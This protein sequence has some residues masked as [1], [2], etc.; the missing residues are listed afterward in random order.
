[1]NAA[2]ERERAKR[3][4]AIETRS[5]DIEK[6]MGL[7]MQQLI[8]PG[9]GGTAKA[10]YIESTAPLER[11]V[12]KNR[13]EFEVSAAELRR[14]VGVSVW[15]YVSA[16]AISEATNGLVGSLQMAYGPGSMGAR[17]EAGYDDKSV[18]AHTAIVMACQVDLRKKLDRWRSVM[19]VKDVEFSYSFFNGLGRQAIVS[20]STFGL[21][22]RAKMEFIRG[23]FRLAYAETMLCLSRHRLVRVMLAGPFA[24]SMLKSDDDFE[25]ELSAISMTYGGKTLSDKAEALKFAIGAVYFWMNLSGQVVKEGLE[26]IWAA[27]DSVLETR[28]DA[29]LDGI[30]QLQVSF[31]T[32][33]DHSTNAAERSSPGVE[34]AKAAGERAVPVPMFAEVGL[35]LLRTLVEHGGD[36]LACLGPFVALT[37]QAIRLAS[38]HSDLW[39]KRSGLV[40]DSRNE[41]CLAS[42]G[43]VAAACEIFRGCADSGSPYESRVQLLEVNDEDLEAYERSGSGWMVGPTTLNR[44]TRIRGGVVNQVDARTDVYVP[45]DDD[46]PSP[47]GFPD[48]VKMA[49][50]H[51]VSERGIRAK[52]VLRR[53]GLESSEGGEMDQHAERIE[54]CCAVLGNVIDSVTMRKGGDVGRAV[55]R[56]DEAI[57]ERVG[58][59]RG[60]LYGRGFTCFMA[61]MRALV[62]TSLTGIGHQVTGR[63]RVLIPGYSVSS[64]D[65]GDL[66]SRDECLPSWSCFGDHR[67]FG[68]E[69]EGWM[70]TVL[71]RSAT[72]VLMST[73]RAAAHISRL[74]AP[75]RPGAVREGGIDPDEILFVRAWV[76]LVWRVLGPSIVEEV[77]EELVVTKCPEEAAAV[78]A[79]AAYNLRKE[80]DRSKLVR[81]VKATAE[82]VEHAVEEM[83]EE[84]EEED[85]EDDDASVI[86]G[87][88]M[89]SSV[90]NGGAVGKIVP[91]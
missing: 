64:R 12:G 10:R 38:F 16:R 54:F 47:A 42:M 39:K 25:A 49:M 89:A 41:V 11:A 32:A 59:I 88:T 83:A 13:A 80:G 4:K 35:F 48:S 52:Q 65:M 24:G 21:E 8:A 1:M 66:A 31:K 14:C 78:F 87:F 60:L 91:Q 27:I 45:V 68:P 36:R 53:G 17:L 67:V 50:K 74:W 6:R 28:A 81:A 75:L 69:K 61:C 58:S 34:W 43:R 3:S 90:Y 30:L 37:E 56:C 84:R 57:R 62:A 76:T 2:R 79:L 40:G 26:D 7:I 46:S 73:H 9:R 51:D 85:D 63:A 70:E 23:V 44:S 15:D 72:G 22:P 82:T 20:S 5:A 55:R 71:Q 77:C 19:G 29:V 33:M 18:F 86:T